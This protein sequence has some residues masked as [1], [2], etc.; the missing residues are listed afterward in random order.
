M[1]SKSK[2]KKEE[3]KAFDMPKPKVKNDAEFSR[4]TQREP[5]VAKEPNPVVENNAYIIAEMEAQRR[6][7]EETVLPYQP[8]PT[9]GESVCNLLG[10]I[11]ERS[12]V[13]NTICR[14]ADESTKIG[15]EEIAGAIQLLA[16]RRRV[17]KN[18]ELA[19]TQKGK[20]RI[21][22]MVDAFNH[23]IKLILEL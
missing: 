3:R 10:R 17:C 11:E 21:I 12:R 16:E 22:N 9:L 6:K 18:Y 19:K 1:S 14:E 20:D 13:E 8:M 23:N 2:D 7:N 4:S 5:F 15:L